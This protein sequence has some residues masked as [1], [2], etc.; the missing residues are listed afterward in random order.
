MNKL[1]DGAARKP[2]SEVERVRAVHHHRRYVKNLPFVF[3]CAFSRASWS[4]SHSLVRRTN[5]MPSSR[6]VNR[7]VDCALAISICEQSPEDTIA[8]PSVTSWLI[9]WFMVI[10]VLVSDSEEDEP[11]Q[12]K[13]SPAWPVPP[14]GRSICDCRGRI[15]DS[16]GPH[17]PVA[18]SLSSI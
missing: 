7:P 16:S 8:P 15:F 14:L 11:R 18:L 4:A 17:G 2:I 12:V 3:G 13:W 10:L 1:V 6:T 9:S 5:P